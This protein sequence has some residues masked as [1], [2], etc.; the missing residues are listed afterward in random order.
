MLAMPPPAVGSIGAPIHINDRAKG[1]VVVGI[2]HLPL[3]AV[4][5]VAQVLEMPADIVRYLEHVQRRIELEE[6]ADV[7]RDVQG[8]VAFV[9]SA[10]QAAEVEP[11]GPGVVRIAVLEGVFQGFFGKQ[12]AVFAEGARQNAVERLLDAAEDFLLG[13]G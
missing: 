7:G 6:T 11:D 1:G 8:G 10:E 12:T 2:G 5:V 3:R 4:I 9:N 13:N